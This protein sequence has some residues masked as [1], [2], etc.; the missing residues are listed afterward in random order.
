MVSPSDRFRSFPDWYINTRRVI[1]AEAEQ[2]QSTQ[3]AQ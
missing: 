3:R 2:A 1:V